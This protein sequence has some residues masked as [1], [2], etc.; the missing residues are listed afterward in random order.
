[1]NIKDQKVEEF[2]ED[3]ASAKPTPGGGAVAAL[4]GA[5]AAALVEMV[6]NLTR[7]EEIKNLGTKVRELRKKFLDLADQDVA[8]FDAVMGAYRSKDK[9]K[10]K[11]GLERAIAVPQQT[12]ELACLV[13]KL[14]RAMI[15]KGNK[16]A[17][18]DAKTAMHLAEA[19]EKSAE[20][21]IRINEESLKKLEA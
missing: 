17:V 21:N 18:S 2:L 6:V 5:T 20:E 7:T 15:E 16:N 13:Q 10:I 4:T 8:A 3:L 14:A 1:M 9:K 19:A 12:K 11:K